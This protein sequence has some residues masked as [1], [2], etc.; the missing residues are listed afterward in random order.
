MKDNWDETKYLE[1]D[2]RNV[3]VDPKLILDNFKKIDKTKT[4]ACATN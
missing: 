3:M 2:P 4:V 1:S